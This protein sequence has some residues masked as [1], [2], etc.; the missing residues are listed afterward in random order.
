[1]FVL[2]NM[3][4]SPLD[5]K[6]ALVLID[7]QRGIVLPPSVPYSGLEV[8]ARCRELAAAFRAAHLPVV[9][10]NVSFS[11]DFADLPKGRDEESLAEKAEEEG[12]A[13]LPPP[14]YDAI[15][16][17][18]DA[19]PTDL[20]ATKHQ[21][22][23]FHGTDLDTQLRRRGVTQ[24]VLAGITTSRGVD[25]TGREAFAHNYS[26][27]YV[28]DAMADRDLVDHDHVIARV[29]PQ[30]GERTTAAEVIGQL[31]ARADGKGGD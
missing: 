1:M 29:F 22:G 27:A 28:V 31:T 13:E 5:P 21:W 8:V 9:L 19:Q 16:D 24:I 26:V 4:L 18:F 11:P 3:P 30:I 7:L 14:G 17:E 20:R 23:A 6:A 2:A 10:V 15:V 12:D 25:T